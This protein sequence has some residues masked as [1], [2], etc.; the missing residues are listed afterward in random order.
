MRR[1]SL[2]RYIKRTKRNRHFTKHHNR[3]VSRY[4]TN[5]QWNLY[6]LSA[7]HHQAFHKLFGNR[8]FAEAAEV[9]QRMEDIHNPGRKK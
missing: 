2:K 3:A 7:E 8:T 4:G 1:I 5:D 6:R 9:L